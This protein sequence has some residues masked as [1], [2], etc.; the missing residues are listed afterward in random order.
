VALGALVSETPK[1]LPEFV[2]TEADG[3]AAF[4]FVNKC[5]ASNDTD[6]ATADNPVRNP[7]LMI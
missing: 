2:L 4:R 3:S 6:N 1:E 5:K 7:L